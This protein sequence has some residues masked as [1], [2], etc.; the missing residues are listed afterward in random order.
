MQLNKSLP[1]FSST[2]LRSFLMIVP[3]RRCSLSPPFAHDVHIF[4]NEQAALWFAYFTHEETWLIFIKVFT[5]SAIQLFVRLKI[6][7]LWANAIK[8]NPTEFLLRIISLDL[9]PKRL[10]PESNV[11]G[12]FHHLA[13]EFWRFTQQVLCLCGHNFGSTQQSNQIVDFARFAAI[14]DLINRSRG[15]EN[16]RMMGW[17]QRSVISVAV[18]SSLMNSYDNC[19]R[20]FRSIAFLKFLC[21]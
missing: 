12:C 5:D 16:P 13:R 1:S 20:C 19:E 2:R 21:L 3:H 9:P 15:G 18:T 8:R 10:F 14:P 4:M 17:I 6:V 7:A 11:S